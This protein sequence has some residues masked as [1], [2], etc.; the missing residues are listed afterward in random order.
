VV[1]L[2]V[3]NSA[4]SQMAEG[5]GRHLA[6]AGVEVCSAGS[7][8]ASV[9]PDAI[10]VMAEVGIDLTDHSSK[11]LAEVAITGADVII[12]LC[13]DE[14]CPAVPGARRLHWPIEDPAGR[15]LDA[16]R[17]ARDELRSRVE[18]LFDRLS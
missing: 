1:F 11:G 10:A 13:A 15:G 18:G 6:P 2:C 5:W 14:I 8:P 9:R 12:T 4:R 7:A 16:F 17:S 3:Q